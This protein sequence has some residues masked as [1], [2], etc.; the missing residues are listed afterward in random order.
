MSGAIRSGLRHLLIAAVITGSLAGCLPSLQVSQRVQADALVSRCRPFI[1]V[2]QLRSRFSVPRWP[3]AGIEAGT[4][5][6]LLSREP[7]RTAAL[8]GLLDLQEWSSIKPDGNP[9][10]HTLAMVSLRQTIS[11]R[12]ALAVSDVTATIAALDC[13]AARSDHLANAIGETHQDISDQ[14]LFAVLASDIFIGVIPGALLLS[15]QAIAAEAI[16]VF[17]GMMAV[18]FGSV[19]TVLHLDQDFRHP[20]NVL[21]EFWEGPSES[22]LFPPVVWKF[23]NDA[24][25]KDPD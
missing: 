16:E 12:I 15:G 2:T 17:G 9:E 13:E 21:R 6:S 1:D 19:D 18:G 5:V 25:D 11:H 7:Q 24:S 14:A 23:L 8:I 10:R 3:G 22:R 20:H 4:P